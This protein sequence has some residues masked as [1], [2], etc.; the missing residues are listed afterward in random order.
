ML[1]ETTL[2]TEF[3]PEEYSGALYCHVEAPGSIPGQG[4]I[5]ME[6]SVSAARP[7]HSTVMSRP[8]LYL[9]KSKAARE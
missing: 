6:N 3:D 2:V 9:V 1:V 8:G 5:Y 4:E 7:A